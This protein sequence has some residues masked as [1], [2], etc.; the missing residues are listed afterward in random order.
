[1]PGRRSTVFRKEALIL[2]ARVL[3]AGRLFCSFP[4]SFPPFVWFGGRR[5]PRTPEPDA[6]AYRAAGRDPAPL[7]N[8]HA[9]GSLA[10]TGDEDEER[11]KKKK[12]QRPRDRGRAGHGQRRPDPRDV[13]VVARGFFIV[14][15]GP[16]FYRD[17][18]RA[19]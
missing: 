16:L 9:A 6:R 3:V 18:P 11:K 19:A 17:Y 4:N 12:A 14:S 5:W 7:T 13:R 15:R 10:R 8:R 1:M 2:A